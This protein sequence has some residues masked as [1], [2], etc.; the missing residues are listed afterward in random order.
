MD[1]LTLRKKIS[2]SRKEGFSDEEIMKAMKKEGIPEKEINRAFR[3]LQKSKRKRKS[4]ENRQKRGQRQ[5]NKRNQSSRTP[6]RKQQEVKQKRK[7]SSSKEV[8]KNRRNTRETAEKRNQGILSA[9]RYKLKQKLFSIRNAYNIYRDDEVVLKAHSK[10]FK[11]HE[12]IK[13]KDKEGTTLFEVKAGQI[14]DIAGDYTLLKDGESLA[15]LEKKFTI[16][17]HKWKI[18]AA[19]GSERLL[20]KIRSKSPILAWLRKFGGLLPFVPNVF[21]LIPH[22][23]VIKTAEDREIGRIDGKFS[24]R[25]TYI[26]EL[27]ELPDASR[28]SIV[29]AAIAVDFLEGN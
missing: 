5:R 25:D 12:E 28:E 4:K 19:D 23:Y 24:I 6:E 3:S 22:Q 29:A 1:V 21:A 7:S 27:D 2:E 26:L 15:T 8:S 17:E 16:A 18:R 10:L 9:N 13:F 11:L 14:T 20:A